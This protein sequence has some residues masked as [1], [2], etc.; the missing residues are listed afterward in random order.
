MEK[1]KDTGKTHCSAYTLDNPFIT[2]KHWVI[3]TFEGL[4]PGSNGRGSGSSLLSKMVA[5]QDS[6]EDN[7]LV[8]YTHAW[9]RREPQAISNI[10]LP[11]R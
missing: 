4:S 2:V 3:C 7:G 5:N 8:A 1:E 9:V 10:T 6:V 11:P